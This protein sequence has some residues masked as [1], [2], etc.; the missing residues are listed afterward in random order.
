M[1]KMPIKINRLAPRTSVQQVALPQNSALH[2]APQA[3]QSQV[4]RKRLPN[5]ESGSTCRFNPR[6]VR[7]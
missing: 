4:V 7:V 1:K 3:P 5:M 2:Y 6:I